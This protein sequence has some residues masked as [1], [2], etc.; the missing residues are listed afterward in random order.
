MYKSC[1]GEN[2]ILNYVGFGNA[3]YTCIHAI[4]YDRM[5][6]RLAI[7]WADGEVKVVMHASEVYGFITF[8]DGTE[9]AFESRC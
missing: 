2:V 6:D 4:A 3:N 9:I 5:R 7:A 1:K 8:E